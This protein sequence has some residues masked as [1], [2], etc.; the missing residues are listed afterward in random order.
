MSDGNR[1]K[2]NHKIR[3]VLQDLVKCRQKC[4]GSGRILYTMKLVKLLKRVNSRWDLDCIQL[5]IIL[6]GEEN[7]KNIGWNTWTVIG[8]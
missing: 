1:S 3:Q 8:V 5:G 2:R 7:F 4:S 6:K